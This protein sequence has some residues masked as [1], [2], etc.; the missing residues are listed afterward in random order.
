MA[1]H[2]GNPLSQTLFTSLYIDKLLWPAPKT[3][4]NA[5]FTKDAQTFEHGLLNTVLRSYCLALIKT[6]GIV[7]QIMNREYYSEV[8]Q[9][10]MFDALRQRLIRA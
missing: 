9:H 10:T 5:S 2:M 8:G 3:L 4:E 1:W 6:C 7:H